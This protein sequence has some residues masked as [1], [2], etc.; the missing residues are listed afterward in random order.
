MHN[1]HELTVKLK[2]IVHNMCPINNK[3]SISTCVLIVITV[4]AELN[5]FKD[6]KMT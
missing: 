4:V 1:F 3:S 6:I 5:V 2:F